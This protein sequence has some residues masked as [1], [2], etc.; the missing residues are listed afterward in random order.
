MT[1]MKNQTENNENGPKHEE[2]NIIDV[3]KCKKCKS[4]YDSLLKHLGQRM[5]C[6][7]AYTEHE[8]K[9]LKHAV[10]QKIKEKILRKKKEYYQK[11]YEKFLQ[12]KADHYQKKKRAKQESKC[13]K[14]K[15]PN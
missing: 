13:T 5:V 3:N 11:N 10:K 2:S 1:S 6:H 12:K 15:L 9:D 8:M 14:N 4:Y 7:Q